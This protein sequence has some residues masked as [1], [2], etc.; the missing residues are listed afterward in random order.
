MRLIEKSVG[1]ND[2]ILKNIK[3]NDVSND[4]KSNEI[5]IVRNIQNLRSHIRKIID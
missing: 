1:S 2:F 4:R 5:F 3:L